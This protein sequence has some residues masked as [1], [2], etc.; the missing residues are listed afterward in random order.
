MKFSKRGQVQSPVKF[1]WTFLTHYLQ[2]YEKKTIFQVVTLN[3]FLTII[4]PNEYVINMPKFSYVYVGVKISK[5]TSVFLL[6]KPTFWIN[7]Y[8][9]NNSCQF[10]QHFLRAFFTVGKMRTW[11]VDEIDHRRPSL[12][13]IFLSA[14]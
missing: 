5:C 12:Y 8:F 1:V 9:V 7:I 13:A 4:F 2:H 3:V 14:Y 6:L 11:N 10:H